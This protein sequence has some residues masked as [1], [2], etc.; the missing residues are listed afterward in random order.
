MPS[1]FFGPSAQQLYG[2][3][4]SPG[5]RPRR[6]G[7]LL[8]YPG[9]QEYMRAHWA[10]RSLASALAVRGF[11][12]L[13]F[14]YRGTGNSSGEPEDATFESC[15]DDARIAGEEL[16]D[17]ERVDDVTVIGMRF[18]A[19]V[20]LHVGVKLPFVRRILLWNPIVSGAEYLDE[21][22][23]MDRA[24]RLQLLHPL[25]RPDGELAGYA[26]PADVRRSIERIDLRVA[27]AGQAPRRVELFVEA[28]AAP[29]PMTS[30]C[31]ALER[32]G[33]TVQSHAITSSEPAAFPD[34][35]LLAQAAIQ[36]LVARA[37]ASDG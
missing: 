18:G 10:F 25:R 23:Q 36:T 32:A 12:V 26:F 17:A 1:V 13:R 34:A 27:S 15:V 28:S 8:L 7:V 3:L 9:V 31:A 16:R 6:T 5:A 19:A 30:L 22:E 21:L 14:D 33:H 29:P 20:G 24:L 35:A 37:E 11:P 2:V 4:E